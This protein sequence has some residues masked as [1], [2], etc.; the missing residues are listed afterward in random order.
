MVCSEIRA[1]V[2]GEKSTGEVSERIP[3]DKQMVIRAMQVVNGIEGGYDLLKLFERA[4]EFYKALPDVK[5]VVPPLF[6]EDVFYA[7]HLGMISD[8]VPPKVLWYIMRAYNKYKSPNLIWKLIPDE[9]LNAIFRDGILGE[10]YTYRDV[11]CTLC[12]KDYSP[13][14]EMHVR[15]VL[16]SHVEVY[17]RSADTVALLPHD[18]AKALTDNDIRNIKVSSKG[19]MI[20]ERYLSTLAGHKGGINS[21]FDLRDVV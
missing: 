20:A 16:S 6:R 10:G 14:D 11:V 18:I 12:D 1:Y 17:V 21:V 7:M 8:V 13:V 15:N 4:D 3:I 5:N 2:L 19:L 9:M